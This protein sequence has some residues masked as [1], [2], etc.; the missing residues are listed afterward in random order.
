MATLRQKAVGVSAAVALATTAL[1]MPWEGLSLRTYRDP[2][3]ILTYCYGETTD[4]VAGRTYTSDQCTAILEARVKGFEDSITHCLSGYPALPTPTKAALISFTYNVGEGAAC[5]STL[6]RKV[7]LGDIR[8]A[9]DE[10]L[11]W[12]KAGGRELK[13]LVN[14]RNAER[15]VCLQGVK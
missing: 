5:K 7:R 15:R 3:G 2:I 11:R 6:F 10:L 4:A 8:G 14:R 1:I 12:T 13:G 9:C